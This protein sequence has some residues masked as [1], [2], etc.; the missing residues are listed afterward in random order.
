MK[1]GICILAQH[2]SKDC[3]MNYPSWISSTLSPRASKNV[4]GVNFTFKPDHITQR[5]YRTNSAFILYGDAELS[6]FA[7]QYLTG[8]CIQGTASRIF[9]KGADRAFG[10]RP[11][12]Q[13]ILGGSRWGK[14]I[15]RTPPHPS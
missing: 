14:D 13:N 5:R 3:R 2:L 8:R 1:N 4:V 15:Y 12:K 9:I 10:P 7:I 11:S 6:N